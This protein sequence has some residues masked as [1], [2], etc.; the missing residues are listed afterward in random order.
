MQA[1]KRY[2]LV[3]LS[4]AFL[5]YCYFGGY[6]LK[7]ERKFSVEDLPSFLDSMDYHFKTGNVHHSTNNIHSSEFS[8]D[9]FQRCRMET[10]FDFEKCH[11]DFKVYVYPSGEEIGEDGEIN[12]EIPS[13][14]Q[15]TAYQKL[16]SVITESRYYTSNPDEACLFILSLDTLDRD[17]LSPDYVRNMPARLQRLRYWNNGRNH[18]IFNLYAGTWPDYLE[19]GLGKFIVMLLKKKTQTLFFKEEGK[20]FHLV[21]YYN[22]QGWRITSDC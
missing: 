13:P 2:L 20:M 18:V 4:C 19:D 5:A 16:I 22:L 11:S 9:N 15:S 17:S 3:L 10:C 1:K 7:S 14:P 21:G 12:A 8:G 6:R